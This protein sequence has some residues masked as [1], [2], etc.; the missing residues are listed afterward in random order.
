[1]IIN[2]KTTSC[3]LKN[4]LTILERQKGENTMIQNGDLSVSRCDCGAITVENNEFS[5]SMTEKTFRKEFPGFRAPRKPDWWSC[6]HCINHWGIDLCGCGSGEPVGECDG[7]FPQCKAGI[8]YQ[9]KGNR[10]L[11]ALEAIIERGRFV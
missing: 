7:D 4:C 1:M 6:N 11:S 3:T 10:T 9:T 5:N 2:G 8:P